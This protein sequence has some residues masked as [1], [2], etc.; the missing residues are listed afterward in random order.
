MT[1]NFQLVDNSAAFEQARKI[2]SVLYQGHPMVRFGEHIF[3][4]TH[5]PPQKFGLNHEDNSSVFFSK[6]SPETFATQKN[7]LFQAE[8]IYNQ[9]SHSDHFS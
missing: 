7:E 3:S 1:K 5:Y 8:G 9:L 6:R 4:E 2:A